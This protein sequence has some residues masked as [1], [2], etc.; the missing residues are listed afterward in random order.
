MLAHGFT[1]AMIVDLVRAE[2]ASVSAERVVITGG[3]TVEIAR[4][5][6]T[7]AGLRLLQGQGR[8]V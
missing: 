2:L 3:T 6:I 8:G 7:E 5:K 4:V 1:T